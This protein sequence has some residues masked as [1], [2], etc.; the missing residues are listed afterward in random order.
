LV[1]TTGIHP[2]MLTGPA[3]RVLVGVLVT[4]AVGYLVT[5]ETGNDPVDL[6]AAAL[7]LLLLAGFVRR[8]L[9]WRRRRVALTDRR[10]LRLSGAVVRRVGSV[11]L[12]QISHVELV[13]GLAGRIMGFGTLE[14]HAGDEII[15]LSG[16]R[17]ASELW[18]LLA[19]R[20]GSEGAHH[21]SLAPGLAFDR[22]DTGPLPRV[23]V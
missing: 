12:E 8:F 4:L 1:F 13:Q 5:P 18:S 16:L 20:P 21:R 3:L 22:Q 6:A 7:A 10:L 19:E 14:V 23:V 11:P 17:R 2:A 9:S 15:V